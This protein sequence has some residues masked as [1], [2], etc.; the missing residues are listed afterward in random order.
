MSPVMA[1]RLRLMIHTH[2]SRRSPH[3][4][5]GCLAKGLPS[6]T[7]RS[8]YGFVGLPVEVKCRILRFLDKKSLR[9][10][11]LVNREMRSICDDELALR[12]QSPEL[13]PPSAEPAQ[14]VQ[15]RPIPRRTASLVA[16][17]L[18]QADHL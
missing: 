11:R 12:I 2:W 17:I 8:Q 5:R 6:S 13:E 4:R 16:T 15:S 7:G 18:I 14:P 9:V 3:E 1:A 10:L